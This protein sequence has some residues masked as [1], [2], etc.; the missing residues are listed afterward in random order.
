MLLVSIFTA[1]TILLALPE[2]VATLSVN[3]GDQSGKIFDG[4]GGLSGGG[5]TSVLLPS[6]PEKEK[7]EILDLLFKPNFGASLHMLKVEIGGDS[8][9]TDGTESSHMHSPDDLDYH[10]GYEWWLL[11]EAKK[12]NPDILTYGL[13]WAYPGWVGGPEQSDSPFTH[14][15]LTSTYILKWLEGARDVYNVT[16]DYIG[17]WNERSSD[18]TYA[19]T[20]RETLNEKGFST[21]KLVAK[22]GNADICNDLAKDPDYAKAIDIIG[23][24]YPS[25][26]NNYSVCHS[27]NKP[28]W[29][30]EESSSYDDLNGAACW[31]R[32]I[33][34]HYALNQMTAS[35]MWN[36]VGSYMHGT[37]W[38]ASSL[39]T[40]VQPWSGFYE[41]E[42]P[43]VWATA[44]LTQFTQPGWRYL[45]DGQGSGELPNGGFYVSLVDGDEYTLNVVKISRDHASCT[46]PGLPEFDVKNETVTFAFT[47]GSPSKSLHVWHSNFEQASSTL[48]QNEGIMKVASDGTFSLDVSVGDMWTVST[49]ATATKGAFPSSSEKTAA[50][51]SASPSAQDTPKFPLPFIE[52]F[53]HYSDSSGAKYW[54]DQIGAYE[55]HNSTLDDV[56]NHVLRQ[57]VPELPIGWSDHGSNGP[58]T[59]LGMR[60]FQDMTASVRYAMPPSAPDV[61]SAC[62][63]HRV[64]QMWNDGIVFCVAN[65]GTWTLSVGGPTLGGGYAAGNLL[66]HGVLSGKPPAMNDWHTLS[67]TTAS[68]QA[69]GLL[70]DVQ[71]FTN[72]KIRDVDT[73]FTAIGMSHWVSVQFDNFN[74]AY[75]PNR[76]ASHASTTHGG[77]KYHVGDT[78]VATDCETNGDIDP[79]QH[80]LLKANSWQLYHVSSGMCAEA[81]DAKN[82]AT[83]SL[84]TCVH[85]KTTQQFRNDYTLIRNTPVQVTLGDYNYKSKLSL[86]GT[87]MNA[88]VILDSKKQVWNTWSYFPNTKQLRNQY[89]SDTTLGYPQ[90]LSVQK[91]TQ[92]NVPHVE[93]ESTKMDF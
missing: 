22:D 52:N 77:G 64:D 7:N 28:I 38:Y 17:I 79:N 33:T 9:S 45:G 83:L 46:R 30:S 91:V 48:F 41:K 21:T 57:M 65:N 74:L 42:M 59:L 88:P 31:G 51:P 26:Y 35:I 47:H 81:S 93:K 54:A 43:V 66:A 63:G 5:A 8:Q 70:D 89:N 69:S 6:Y 13:P 34:S 37:N 56:P 72:I 14:P 67:L 12:R 29:A 19:E 87:G 20:L 76:R 44:H 2:A 27:L 11:S 86:Q 82:G 80:F 61:A 60:E 62:I 1:L 15:N 78:L 16:T 53:E 32:V 50:S 49:I 58:M 3:I 55:I 84:Q 23:L 36:L 68:D 40:A 24:H 92:L 25:D 90:C 18:A 71:V 85:G 4:I 75:A 73:G 10:R 39:L